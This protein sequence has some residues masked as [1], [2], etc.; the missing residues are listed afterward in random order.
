M[1]PLRHYFSPIF[2]PPRHSPPFFAMIS[3]IAS[4]HA[5]AIIT[6][7]APDDFR[8]SPFS[9]QRHYATPL[10]MLLAFRYLPF[11]YFRFRCF[12]FAAHMMLSYC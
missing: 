3:F 2:S 6:L 5:R 4:A 9:R 11:R 8:L 10:L 7:M 12:I 1:P